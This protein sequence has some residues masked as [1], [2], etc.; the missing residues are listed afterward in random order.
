MTRVRSPRGLLPVVG[1]CAATAT[2]V[3]M[4]SF[5]MLPV[6]RTASPDEGQPLSIDQLRDTDEIVPTPDPSDAS[7]SEPPPPAAQHSAASPSPSKPTPSRTR[8]STPPA[9]Q[10]TTTT[11]TKDA[12]A[13]ETSTEDGWTVTTQGDG[14]RSYVRSFRV[15]GGQAV[16]NAS[17]GVI[18]LVTAT[19]SDGFSVQKVQNTDDNLAVY[20]NEVNHSFIIHV[21][22]QNDK[23]FAQVDEVG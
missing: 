10:P 21:V 22:W 14:K 6:L 16:I 23:P 9:T 4:A 20:F 19:P 8:K 3:V 5:A 17:A 15:E 11:P 12:K 7:P 2:S 18:K 1:W 13:A